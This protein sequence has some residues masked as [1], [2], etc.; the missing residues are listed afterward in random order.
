MP[1]DNLQK[2]NKY[3]ENYI[4]KMLILDIELLKK[5]NDELK[6]SYPY[7]LLAC[8]GIDLFGGIEK[9]FT[10]PNGKGNSKERFMWFITEWMGK[11]NVLYK[12]ES[13]AYLIYDSWRCGVSHQATLKKGFETSSFMYNT[14][15]HLHY[16]QDKDRVYIHSLQFADDF[17]EAQKLYRHHIN[18]SAT[19]NSYIELLYG[20]LLNMINEDQE[21]KNQSFEGFTK[22]LQ[23][24]GLVFNTTHPSSQYPPITYLP[25]KDEIE[26]MPSM[27]PEEDDLKRE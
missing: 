23:D 10:K 1:N 2:L 14:D 4:D 5:R 19:S 9:D 22:I 6:F 12:E 27:A 11:I 24:K 17:I 18:D 3:F 7:L 15:K 8:S 26:P 20:H 25:N 16:I 13:L 21:E